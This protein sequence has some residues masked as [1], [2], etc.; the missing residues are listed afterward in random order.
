MKPNYDFFAVG[1]KVQSYDKDGYFLMNACGYIVKHLGEGHAIIKTFD[2]A[3]FSTVS[4]L[5]R[6]VEIESI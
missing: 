1:S 2:G 4:L 6:V 5:R 3:F